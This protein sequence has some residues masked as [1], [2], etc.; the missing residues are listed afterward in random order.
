MRTRKALAISG[1][2]IVVVAV[3]A[4][5]ICFS[6]QQNRFEPDP[7]PT[8]YLRSTYNEDTQTIRCEPKS[9]FLSTIGTAYNCVIQSTFPQTVNDTPKTINITWIRYDNVDYSQNIS[10]Q[11]YEKSIGGIPPNFTIH[12]PPVKGRYTLAVSGES[13][14]FRVRFKNSTATYNVESRE[15]KSFSEKKQRLEYLWVYDPVEK[16]TIQY[17]NLVFPLQLLGT[18]IIV[19]SSAQLCLQ[20]LE[21]R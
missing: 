21:Y 12:S 5:L 6:P 4:A 7:A 13:P 17:R 2:V 16:T 11:L 8:I 15:L 18:I 1:T 9:K 10:P 3:L 14:R 19:I 20:I